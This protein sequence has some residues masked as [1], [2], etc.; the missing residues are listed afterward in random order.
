MSC[1]IGL[2]ND[3]GAAHLAYL[4]GMKAYLSN[5]AGD[6]FQNESFYQNIS[7]EAWDRVTQYLSDNIIL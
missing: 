1:N 5:V 7:E 2:S 4:L 3:C 6:Y